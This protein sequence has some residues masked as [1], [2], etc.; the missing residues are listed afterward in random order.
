MDYVVNERLP[1]LKWRRYASD[2]EVRDYPID[3]YDYE[4]Y[5]KG[6]LYNSI[7]S[8]QRKTSR[9]ATVRPSNTQ[10]RPQSPSTS[11]AGSIS[12][13]TL[14]SSPRSSKSHA[15]S[16]PTTDT[17][18][19]Y[20]SSPITPSPL[21]QTHLGLHLPPITY[22]LLP[23]S[24]RGCYFS[25]EPAFK[26]SPIVPSFA[27]QS[28][29]GLRRPHQSPAESFSPTT[30]VGTPREFHVES[31]TPFRPPVDGSETWAWDTPQKIGSG[32]QQSLVQSFAYPHPSESGSNQVFELEGDSPLP[33][34]VDGVDT[35]PRRAPLNILRG[36][37]QSPVQSFAH[38]QEAGTRTSQV[39]ELEGDSQFPPRVDDRS[40]GPRDAPLAQHG[41]GESQRP[42]D[43]T[44]AHAQAAGITSRTAPA[45]K[46]EGE[47]YFP[48]HV[49]GPTTNH[50]GRKQDEAKVSY[51]SP[52]DLL[53]RGER[54]GWRRG[55]GC[56][57][58][59]DL[60]AQIEAQLAGKRKL[61]KPRPSSK[62]SERNK[63][64]KVLPIP[65]EEEGKCN[66]V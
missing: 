2:D 44:Y 28:Q 54:E 57:P 66:I 62:G 53:P 61:Q 64:K 29:V 1:D 37:H 65:G 17:Y 46:L 15:A 4:W 45:I 52:D 32:P 19:N 50:H 56:P 7:L 6:D 24:Y 13:S 8:G 18:Q 25:P 9:A 40:T 10:T 22:S 38:L 14:V 34:Q 39:F 23:N 5:P 3:Y 35:S 63:L 11:Y 48:L 42:L 51:H 21:P 30:G 20:H 41:G 26:L 27:S 36:P 47:P 59:L 33:T 49:D 60:E 55:L 58:D 16:G 12:S 31:Q 43:Q